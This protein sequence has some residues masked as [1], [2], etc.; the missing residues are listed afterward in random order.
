M[1]EL[2]HVDFVRAGKLLLAEVSL[3]ADRTA[4]A[5]AGRTDFS[6]MTARTIYS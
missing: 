6:R 2:K 5:P 4:L 3:A 1:L